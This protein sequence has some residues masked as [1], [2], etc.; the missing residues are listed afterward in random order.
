MKKVSMI[1]LV[2]IFVVFST[3]IA[4]AQASNAKMES[5]FMYNFTKLVNWPAAY[6]SGDFVIGVLGSSP[7]IPELEEMAKTKKAGTQNI[8]VAKF[9][10][11]ASITKCHILFIPE[12]QS[13]NIGAV[14]GKVSGSS[15][16]LVSETANGTSSGAAINFVIVDNKQKFEL[17]ESNATKYGLVIGAQLKNLAIVK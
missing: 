8:V 2:S 12:S 13:A 5:V 6:Q 11:V 3:K 9:S 15:T 1:L 14:A 7:I 16:L 10:S 17:K 4:D